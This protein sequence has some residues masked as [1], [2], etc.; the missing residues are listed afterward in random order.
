MEILFSI[1]V[2]ALNPG[3]K[4]QKTIDSIL[5]QK[6]AGSME[7]LVKDG[8]STDGSIEAAEAGY[9]VSGKCRFI[10]CPDRSIYDAMNQALEAAAGRYVLF[11]NCGDTFYNEEVL[12]QVAERIR[13]DEDG[14]GDGRAPAARIYYGNTLCEQTGAVVHSAPRITGFTCYRNIPCHQSCFYDRR[15]FAEKKYDT[16]YR[17]RADYDHFLWCFYRGGAEMV[18]LD[19]IVSAYEGGGY[20]EDRKNR[21]LDR[22]EHR[23]VTAEYMSKREL[24]GYRLALLLTLAPLRSWMA[25]NPRFAGIYHKMKDW[26]YRRQG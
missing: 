14:E 4:L 26:V 22:Q 5:R 20:S 23:R 21:D 15:L 24:A 10:R 6:F 2:V 11:L 17:I 25:G 13:R 1:L 3:D 7:I 18:Y 12:G 9:G 19:L 8:M 16:G